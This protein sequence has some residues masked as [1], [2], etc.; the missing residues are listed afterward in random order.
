MSEPSER[1]GSKFAT[2]GK[3]VYIC[4]A[5]ILL[6]LT[7]AGKWLP[8]EQRELRRQLN[9]A[10]ALLETKPAGRAAPTDV[11][12]DE[13]NRKQ[14]AIRRQ[15][16][17]L[18]IDSLLTGFADA[19]SRYERF[20]VHESALYPYV[21]ALQIAYDPAIPKLDAAV[22]REKD[23]HVALF[24]R[25]LQLASLAILARGGDVVSKTPPQK[26]DKMTQL[27]RAA[28]TD[29]LEVVRRS[30]R[31]TFAVV[32]LLAF[33]RTYN[34]TQAAS[35]MFANAF[36]VDPQSAELFDE[37]LIHHDA[38]WGR[39][40]IKDN[41]DLLQ[42]AK[43]NGVSSP[44]LEQTGRFLFYN[45]LGRYASSTAPD[46]IALATQ[47]AKAQNNYDAWGWLAKVLRTQGKYAEAISASQTAAAMRPFDTK[48]DD[49]I[50][51]SLEMLG[52]LDEAQ[53][54][55]QR[56]AARGSNYAQQRL[57]DA[58]VHSWWGLQRN[59]QT[60]RSICEHSADM[61]NAAG[62]FCIGGLYF[63]SLGGYPRDPA[64]AA[65][66]FRRAAE[67]Y[68]DTAQHDFGWMLANGKGGLTQDRTEGVYWLRQASQQGFAKADEKLNALGEAK[69][70]L[71][72]KWWQAENAAKRMV[73]PVLWKLLDRLP[74]F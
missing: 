2:T 17:K 53:R 35:S 50:G 38:R 46:A 20:E 28:A 73:M 60:V 15:L 49:D 3:A 22:A 69:E 56:A 55:Y 57:I 59:W 64:V 33:A 39:K 48:N 18:D 42:L 40:T 4:I 1:I 62:Q 37:Y 13:D 47:Y 12:H 31:P 16:A 58:N 70:P 67:Q 52:R 65:T 63:D 36:R 25:G 7:I 29:L 43:Q 9:E 71:S 54:V 44:A 32:Q 8:S 6:V 41:A 74:T 61:L 5:L 11:Y 27:Q 10:V 34:H 14:I 23:G 21:Y 30:P 68:H 24:A 19:L 66:W 26:F 51:Y 45:E 72:H